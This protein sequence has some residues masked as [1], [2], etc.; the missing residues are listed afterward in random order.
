MGQNICRLGDVGSEDMGKRKHR[1]QEIGVR[2]LAGLW[3]WE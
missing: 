1:K 2:M 3:L